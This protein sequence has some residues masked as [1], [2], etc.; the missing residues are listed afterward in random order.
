[1]EN[2]NSERSLGTI[3]RDLT[4]HLSTLVRSEIALAKLEMKQTA[5]TLGGAGALFVGA[6]FCV[7][8]AV[9]FLLVTAA[10]GLSELGVPP[11]LS[12]LIVGVLLLITA[13]V[14]A[15]VGRKKLRA[16]QIVPA[17]TMESIK[18][19]VATIKEDLTRL[20]QKAV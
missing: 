9:A 13:L 20:R 19:D 15:V 17:S 12:S 8:F 18:T 3:V 4:E 1:M 6:L 7:L 16:L 5:V 2:S 11:W 14:L 10:L